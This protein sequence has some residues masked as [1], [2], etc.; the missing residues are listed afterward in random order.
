MLK[1]LIKAILFAL[2][3]V[4]G[5]VL[6]LC[7]FFWVRVVGDYVGQYGQ[8]G[9]LTSGQCLLTVLGAAI[10]YVLAIAVH[11]AGHWLSGK[12]QGFIGIR[13]VVLWLR[14]E[15]N[16]PRWTMKW[17][18][19]P[20]NMSGMVIQYPSS[21]HALIRRK[22]WSVAA[23]PG[24]NL[25]TGLLALA[26][27]AASL[28]PVSTQPRT[29]IVVLAAE[30]LVFA[31]F[32]LVMG[33]FNLL[34]RRINSG[35]SND[36]HLLWLLWRHRP[37][38]HR[39]LAVAALVGS[40]YAGLRP[41]E[42]ETALV[43]RV[44]ANADDS[45]VDCS[46]FLLAYTHHLDAHRLEQARPLL[47]ACLEKRDCLTEESQQQV[48]CE[49]AYFEA[50]HGQ[51]AVRAQHWLEQAQQVKA[52]TNEDGHF[53]LAEVAWA[54]GEYEKA[55]THFKRAETEPLVLDKNDIGTYKLALDRIADLRARLASGPVAPAIIESM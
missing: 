54:S 44:L 26:V 4:L 19:L 30:L 27:G 31:L 21:G 8:P 18:K 15:R 3:F 39:Q 36:G 2:R 1:G 53:A 40:S 7:L 5:V 38:L 23:G 6:F 9:A 45:V 17:T 32:S 55:H 10:M 20:S 13:F 48:C 47:Y 11:E 43:A 52:F 41:R 42:W 14:I 35:I 37:V 34:P 22:F 24:A 51:D 33:I 12:A 46:A 28:L 16:G 50:C 29:G 25:L 49:A